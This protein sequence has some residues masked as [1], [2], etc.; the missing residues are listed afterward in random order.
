MVIQELYAKGGRKFAF[1]SLSSLGCLPVLRALNPRKEGGCFEEATALAMAHN[2]AF[3]SVLANLEHLLKDFSY[4]NS[5]FSI[6]LDDRINNPLNHGT[7]FLLS[8][9]LCSIIFGQTVPDNLVNDH[10]LFHVLCHY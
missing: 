2:N 9:L 8:K 3:S 6:W 1:L 7:K 4:C 10:Q 5:K